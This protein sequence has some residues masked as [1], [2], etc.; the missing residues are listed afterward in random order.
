MVREARWAAVLGV[1]ERKIRL[2]TCAH[3]YCTDVF[4]CL[5]ISGQS[6]QVNDEQGT[7]GVGC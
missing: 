5:G 7:H 6:G 3:T 1:A 2:S 4:L